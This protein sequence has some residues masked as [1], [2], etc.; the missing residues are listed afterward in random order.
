MLIKERLIQA[1][2]KKGLTQIDMAKR[3]G[4]NQSFYCRIESGKKTCPLNVATDIAEILE[5]SLDWLLGKGE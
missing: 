2:E 5:V 4:F 3:L 1:R